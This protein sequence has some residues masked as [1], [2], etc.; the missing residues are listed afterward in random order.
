MKDHDKAV[1]NL[2]NTVF[3]IVGAILCGIEFGL[4]IGVAVFFLASALMRIERS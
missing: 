1:N 3:V 4:Y 2:V